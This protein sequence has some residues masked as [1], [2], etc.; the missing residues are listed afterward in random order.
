[1]TQSIA[2]HAQET[3][4]EIIKIENDTIYFIEHWYNDDGMLLEK[5]YC[6][7]LE[8]Q[9]DFDDEDLYMRSMRRF[10]E[11]DSIRVFVYDENWNLEKSY[12]IKNR[13][14][15]MPYSSE[16]ISIEQDFIRIEGM[17]N[18]EKMVNLVFKNTTAQ[19]YTLDLYSKSKNVDLPTPSQLFIN[20]SKKNYPITIK[21]G[22]GIDN[23]EII[24]SNSNG[25]KKTVRLE[26]IGYDIADKDFVKEPSETVLTEIETKD[27]IFIEIKGDEKLLL[28]NSGKDRQQA[29]VSRLINKVSKEHFKEG[30]NSLEL[31][32]LTTGEK[33]HCRI[34][35]K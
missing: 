20:R 9:K 11:L 8:S 12:S 4:Q 7:S 31:I 17:A 6:R 34:F 27:E 10:Y 24:A 16:Q 35:L 3:E 33:R 1:M 18:T 30:I 28:I 22:H 25:F 15:D 2:L 13:A 26:I 19:D 5:R 21:L 32:N 29:P 14:E 23:V